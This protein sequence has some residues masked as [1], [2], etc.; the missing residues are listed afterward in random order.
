MSL[1]NWAA[2]AAVVLGLVGPTLV[3]QT[4]AHAADLS[5]MDAYPPGSPYDD[6]RYGDIYRH[7]P[8]PR[9]AAPYPDAYRPGYREP[10][11]RD[12]DGYLREMPP[13]RAYGQYGGD[14]GG[15]YRGEERNG[16]ACLPRHVVREQLER[17]GWSEFQDVD[18]RGDVA[19]LR[20]RHGNGRWFDLSIDR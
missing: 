18:L 7:P 15:A 1:R 13:P 2:A 14:R 5:D 20:A 17:R 12:R 6:P 10:A 3:R 8:P 11:I 9:F 16:D 19:Y 4:P